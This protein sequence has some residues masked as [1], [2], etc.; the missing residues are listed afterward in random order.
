LIYISSDGIF[1]KS[2]PSGSVTVTLPSGTVHDGCSTTIVGVAGG[3]DGGLI[4][5]VKGGEAHNVELLAT[6]EYVP[7]AY[8]KIS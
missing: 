3:G 7:G 5:T 2:A 1:T 6:M 8:L 4:T